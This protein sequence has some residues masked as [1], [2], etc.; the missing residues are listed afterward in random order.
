[1]EFRHNKSYYEPTRSFE[2][3]PPRTFFHYCYFN[4]ILICDILKITQRK[5][6]NSRISICHLSST[7][8]VCS[9]FTILIDIF[10]GYFSISMKPQRPL[11]FPVQAGRL[12]GF[13]LESW[14][15][16]DADFSATFVTFLNS[17]I[18]ALKIIRVI[19]NLLYFSGSSQAL[20]GLCCVRLG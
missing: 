12:D 6:C 18:W 2:T 8:W 20:R 11:S 17:S 14:A 10:Q 4:T 1:M 7:N 15:V 16:P 9:I 13:L 19:F 3:N 5:I